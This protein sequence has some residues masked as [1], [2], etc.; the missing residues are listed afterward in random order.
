[1]AISIRYGQFS[2]PF[3][4]FSPLEQPS[5]CRQIDFIERIISNDVQGTKHKP[6]NSI[7]N[8]NDIENV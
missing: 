4:F 7:I 5:Q 3:N 8:E 6:A 1:M 2:Q